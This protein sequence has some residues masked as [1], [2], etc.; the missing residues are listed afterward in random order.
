MGTLAG[1]GMAALACGAVLAIIVVVAF[2]SHR[3]Q[4]QTRLEYITR[5]KRE[6]PDATR[7]QFTAWFAE[8]GV[9]PS[10]A[11]TVYDYV[12]GRCDIPG[13]PLAP[14][15]PLERVCDIVVH[16]ELDDILRAMGYQ[17]LEDSEWDVL[18]WDALGLP[19]PSEPNAPV[20]SLVHLVDALEKR[21]R[22]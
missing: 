14:D 18:D 22:A 1:V 19:P 9:E 12:Q 21:R 17:P 3:R 2:V 4:R 15:D 7:E 8:R 16:E 10:V 6:R 5:L 13:F 11:T 20:A